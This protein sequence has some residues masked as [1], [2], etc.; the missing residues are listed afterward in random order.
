MV[1]KIDHLGIL[2]DDIDHNRSLFE[3]LGL[4]VG[5]VE[6]VPAFGVEIAFIRV[7]ESLV[8]LVEP[9]GPTTDLAADLEAAGRE[10]MLHHLAFRV[11]DLESQLAEL[12]R[13][14]VALA[15]ET[16]RQGAGDASVAFL[17]RRAAN[18]VRIELVERERD[19]TID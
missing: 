12:R 8:E 15:D 13:A 6:R 18:G 9:V 3:R 2:V 10:A 19:L 1:S 5:A 14:G 17:E 7:G 16:P 4:E 11:D